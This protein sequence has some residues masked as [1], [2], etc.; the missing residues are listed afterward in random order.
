M[1]ERSDDHLPRTRRSLE[2]AGGVH[3]VAHGG[4]FAGGAHCPDEH[5]AGVHTDSHL[6]AD[7]E[8]LAEGGEGALHLERGPHRPL[9]VV[10]VGDGRPEQRHDGVADDLVDLTPEGGDVG[11][12]PFE[13]AV[14]EVLHVLGVSRLGESGEPDQVGEQDRGDAPL[15]GPEHERVAARRAEPR[16]VRRGRAA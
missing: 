2:A 13:A 5:L 14:D 15:V 11:D 1:R 4:V 9:G 8:V 10:F 6:G 7:A 16:L 3:D 12:E